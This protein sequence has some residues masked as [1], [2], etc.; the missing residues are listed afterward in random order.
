MIKAP[1]KP[2]FCLSP[3]PHSPS[4]LS[5]SLSPLALFFLSARLSI[6]ALGHG[7]GNLFP[8]CLDNA[9]SYSS[10]HTVS[11][12][13]IAKAMLPWD[14]IIARRKRLTVCMDVQYV[15]V[16]MCVCINI[17]NVCENMMNV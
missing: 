15:C 8:S 9:I 11:V 12:G 6:A 17:S 3:P 13:T 10:N 14:Y 2:S 7:A 1:I 16:C 4:S 5:L